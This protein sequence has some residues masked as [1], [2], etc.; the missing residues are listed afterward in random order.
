MAGCP[1]I[2]SCRFVTGIYAGTADNAAF[3]KAAATGSDIVSER[4][5]RSFTFLKG[6]ERLWRKRRKGDEKA[7]AGSSYAGAMRLQVG[8]I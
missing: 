8:M 7:C 1:G 6:A 3:D 4:G 2:S 5:S